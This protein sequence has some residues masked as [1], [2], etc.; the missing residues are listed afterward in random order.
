VRLDQARRPKHRCGGLRWLDLLRGS[1]LLA[2]TF[3]GRVRLGEHVT[4]RK[5][6]V[7]L[8]RE[9]LDERTGD[10]LLERARRAL[11]LDPVI[12]LQQRKNFLARRPEQFGDLVNP[13]RCQ[14]VSCLS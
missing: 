14:I 6:D 3:G 10:D 2:A 1:R 7:A 13:D 8:P 9:P 5:R 4:A 11:Q 12:S